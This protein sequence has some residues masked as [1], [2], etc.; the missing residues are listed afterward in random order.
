[1]TET[2]TIERWLSFGVSGIFT[3]LAIWGVIAFFPSKKERGD[4]G[5]AWLILAVWLGFVGVGLNVFYW[6]VF[7]DLAVHFGWFTILEIRWFGNTWGDII[8]KGTG[9]VSIYLHF[10]SRWK[11]LPEEEQKDWRPL[12][13]GWYPDT[14]HWMVRFGTWKRQKDKTSKEKYD[15]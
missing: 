7:G 9:A 4:S 12:L 3:W 11:F 1:M 15:E 13:M 14:H 8:W 5:P 10:Y 6:R 2:M